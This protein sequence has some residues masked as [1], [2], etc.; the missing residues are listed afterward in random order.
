MKHLILK[1]MFI[2]NNPF[3]QKSFTC[4]NRS[5]EFIDHCDLGT[6]VLQDGSS[7][8]TIRET[9]NYKLMYNYDPKNEIYSY[10]FHGRKPSS[11]YN[12]GYSLVKNITKSGI[13]GVS[14][15][16]CTGEENYLVEAN[17][18]FM[19][20][21]GHLSAEKLPL[22]CFD[23]ILIICYIIYL[24]FWISKFI[25]YAKYATKLHYFV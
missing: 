18:I 7:Y 23:F 8:Y 10:S 12:L 25:K 15:I 20:P 9:N 17:I 2:N 1:I 16:E 5:K 24:A 22:L 6:I 4:C 14:I 11:V 3:T 13:Y 19:N 21:F